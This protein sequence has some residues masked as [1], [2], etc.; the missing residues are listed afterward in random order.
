MPEDMPSFRSQ[1]SAHLYNMAEPTSRPMA[2]YTLEQICFSEALADR[3][4]RKKKDR[5]FHS[6]GCYLGPFFFTRYLPGEYKNYCGVAYPDHLFTENDKD[7]FRHSVA[8]A[9]YNE[10]EFSDDEK[11]TNDGKSDMFWSFSANFRRS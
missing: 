1:Y 9:I 6:D 4:L 5:Y 3:L 8:F 7:M 2:T 10:L 11:F